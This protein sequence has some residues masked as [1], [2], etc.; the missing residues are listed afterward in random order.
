[1]SM[2]KTSEFGA[3]LIHG[4]TGFSQEMEGLARMLGED[5]YKVV[6]TVLPG[7]ERTPE[8]LRKTRWTDYWNHLEREFQLLGQECPGGVF[9]LGQSM[10]GAL[11]LLLAERLSVKGIVTFAAPVRLTGIPVRLASLLG[12]LIPWKV[13]AAEPME[14]QIEDPEMQGIHRCY[15]HFHLESL[16]ELLRLLKEVRGNLDKVT[17][18]ILV[19]HAKKD[20]VVHPANMDWILRGVSS[21]V[22]ESLL[23]S[24]GRHPI[25]MDLGRHEAFEATRTFL[26]RILSER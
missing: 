1:M 17:A 20:K 6:N 4:F 22:K 13:I 11:S 14:V 2:P 15:P 16:T 21:E 5:G 9:C 25:T 7:H 23:L 24:Q 12:P 3:L 18:P 26:Q 19:T 10:G 8:D